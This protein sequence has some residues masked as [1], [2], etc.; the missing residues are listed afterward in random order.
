MQV[1]LR[2]NSGECPEERLFMKKN[3][4]SISRRSFLKSS[5]ITASGL[6]IPSKALAEKSVT[7]TLQVWSCGGLAEAFVPANKAFER[8]TGVRISYTGA[9]AA[10]LGKSLLGSATTEVFAPRVITLSK[11]LKDEGKMLWY[12]PLCF[13]RY[14]IAVPEDNP[15]GVTSVKDLAKPDMRVVL[16]FGSS[17][18]GGEATKVLL[19]KAGVLE[20]VE[21]NA[22]FNGDCVQR[23]TRML[24]N[25]KADAAIVEQRIT[26]LPEFRGKLDMIPID[27]EYF[28]PP[29]MT[30]TIGLMKWAENPEVARKYIDFILSTE[31]QKCFED[32]GFIPA[33]SDEGR[34][35]SKKYGV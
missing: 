26:C 4:G 19:K 7:G 14:I 1:R 30:F 2:R 22:V 35:L 5:G 6:L 21:E 11:K 13:T 32:A 28:P 29:P 17:A 33:A 10:A 20:G 27:E 34:R 24:I 31:G 25:G 9:F 12:K 15:A 16:S 23:T 8:N 18:P 3:L